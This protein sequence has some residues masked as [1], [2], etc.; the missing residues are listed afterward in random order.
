MRKILLLLLL[1]SAVHF[2]QVYNSQYFADNGEAYFRF[3]VFDKAEINELS[4]IISIDKI[5]EEYVYAYASEKEFKSFLKYGYG[6]EA[7]KHPGDVPVDMA[8][9]IEGT[10]AWDV[11][12]TYDVYVQML[13]Q[14]EMLYPNICKIIDAGTTVQGRKILFAKISDNVNMNEDEPEFMFSSTIHGDETTGY[15]LMLR[16]IDSLLNSYGENSRIT[17]IVNSM[18]I[19]INPNANPDGTYRNGNNTLSGARRYNANSVDLNRNFPDPA[20]GLHPDGN[21]WQPEVTAMMNLAQQKN[22]VFST[23]FHGGAEVVN[24]PW[25]TW[26]RL[27]PDNGWFYNISRKYADTVH[28]HAPSGYLTDLS[29]GITN[30]YAWYRITGGRQDY[31]TYYRRG[32][33]V[34]IEISETKL[35]SASL[36]PSFWEYNKRSFLNWMEESLKGLRGVITNPQGAPVKAKITIQGHDFD[37]SEIFSDS[38]SGNYHRFIAAG[39]YTVVISADSH[40]TKTYTNVTVGTG[41]VTT[42]NA[43][44]EPTNPVPV[45]LT[46]FTAVSNGGRVIIEW[47]TG[48]ETNNKG[49][50]ISIRKK[51]DTDKKGAIMIR[52][53]GKGTTAEESSYRT[54]RTLEKGIYMVGLRQIDFDG[55]SVS[56]EEIEVEVVA[57]VSFTLMQNYPNPFNPSTVIAYRLPEESRVILRVYDLLGREV[58]TLVNKEEEA[59]EYSVEFDGRGLSSGIYFY[60]IETFGAGGNLT[61]GNFAKM[62]LNK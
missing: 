47:K 30:G 12:P 25:D 31:F 32:R 56:A 13:T 35:P 48:T 61:Y 20:D 39:T 43:I 14:Y 54:E 9:S 27:H 57:P 15:V 60:R 37:N 8:T 45:E 40:H 24:Y 41:G 11:Y 34:T 1:L 17:N 23:N 3:K 33:E 36:L 5:A 2:G 21:A 58:S 44:L 19:W 49:F 26:S 52:V 53:E 62:V 42:I 6:Y 38:L 46:S 59:G 51:E 55:T 7:L 22:F 10:E 28:A 29:N 18:E 16:L 50:E 4:K